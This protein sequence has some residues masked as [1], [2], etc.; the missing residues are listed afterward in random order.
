VSRR[1]FTIGQGSRFSFDLSKLALPD[2][3]SVARTGGTIYAAR[4]AVSA[5]AVAGAD[6]Y[7]DR[8]DGR[9]GG[10]WVFDAYTNQIADPFA[11]LGEHWAVIN[12]LVRTADIGAGPDGATQAMRLR[13]SDP[14]ALAYLFW[15]GVAPGT[16]L[17]GETPTQFSLW[18]RDTSGD[19]PTS[20]GSITA[21]SSYVLTPNGTGT[22]WKRKASCFS[23]SSGAGQAD[24]GQIY[25]AGKAYDADYIQVDTVAA[26][27][28][29]DVWGAQVTHALGDVPLLVGS[30][31]AAVMTVD[32]PAN[33][34]LPNGDLHIEGE[35]WWDDR[36][37]LDRQ[38]V[39]WNGTLYLFSMQTPSG[40]AALHFSQS[41]GMR[42]T[43]NGT[44]SP[45]GNYGYTPTEYVNHLLRWEFWNRPSDN[46]G[47]YNLWW[48]GCRYGGQN[49]SAFRYAAVAQATPTSLY[50]NSNLGAAGSA[51]PAPVTLLRRVDQA[52]PGGR[53][54]VG[55]D[56]EAAEGVILGDSIVT[57]VSPWGF[58]TG[59]YI[60]T[61]SEGKTRRG[62]VSFADSGFTIA[63]Q[64]SQW[65][66]SAQRGRSD[67]QWLIIQLGVNDIITGR[68]EVQM[69]TDMQALIDDIN[70]QNP[71]AKILLSPMTPCK[72]IYTGPQYALWLAFNADIAG[73][74][75][76]P[77]TGSNLIR[78]SPW[79]SLNDGAG[80]L[81]ALYDGG[82]GY[83]D[84]V[85]PNDTGRFIQAAAFRAA[86][87]AE[88]LL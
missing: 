16:P 62:I 9:G 87:V 21:F 67:I 83:V 29:I 19:A 48:N 43:V 4:S 32:T 86:L 33:A 60:Y 84:G 26:T 56:F 2:G 13:D 73:S 80:N 76:I 41:V 1:A 61:V 51:L 75:A 88:G 11:F 39:S 12:T 37:R 68:T 34:L 74:G 72:A 52:A 44:D 38:P 5:V 57:A 28:A 27:G 45:N 14:A 54:D 59:A 64:T 24:Y 18:L 47:G 42:A 22:T 55:T 78:L 7:E 23:K 70:T 36:D 25:P 58:Y 79:A 81:A 77:I 50:L 82:N 35:F 71:T 20:P 49:R 15:V 8:G 10:H 53:R 63:G 17:E 31:S 6:V 40:L 46:K 69:T 3:I 65:T 30:S 66:S 85:H